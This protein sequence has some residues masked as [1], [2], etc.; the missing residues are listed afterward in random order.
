[1]QGEVV[2]I[3][4]GRVQRV[5]K[6]ED[7]G[8][9]FGFVSAL[10]RRSSLNAEL[11]PVTIVSVVSPLLLHHCALSQR[12]PTVHLLRIHHHWE[13]STRFIPSYCPFRSTP[14]RRCALDRGVRVGV[15]VDDDVCLCRGLCHSTR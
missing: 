14:R 5:E 4:G 11:E 9:L 2:A 8:T 1:M 7:E 3:E 15:L 10:R 13:Q 12:R 6:D